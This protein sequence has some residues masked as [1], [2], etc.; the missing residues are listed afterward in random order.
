M[1]TIPATSLPGLIGS[2]ALAF[3]TAGPA[4][5][6]VQQPITPN[7]FGPTT[8]GTPVSAQLT[9]VG[10][11]GICFNWS[12]AGNVP[13]G[14]SLANTVATTSATYQGTPT[15]PSANP[16]LFEVF[17]VAT[18]CPGA[19]QPNPVTLIQPMSHVVNAAA[20]GISPLTAP[21][22]AVGVAYSQT[23]TQTGGL[24]PGSVGLSGG[25]LPPGL[26]LTRLGNTAVLAGT[27]ST[28]GIYGFNLVAA[29]VQNNTIIRSYTVVISSATP[30][31]FVTGPALPAAAVG[32]AYSVTLQT[33]GGVPPV[34]G[35][36]DPDP[37]MPPGLTIDMA[38]LTIS[39]TPAAA[40]DYSF[41][42][43]AQDALSNRTSRTFTLT[44]LPA[45]RIITTSLPNGTVSQPYYAQIQTEGSPGPVTFSY[46]G[47][48]PPGL[49]L[50]A[51]NGVVSGAPSSAGRFSF[52]VTAASGNRSTAPAGY[53]VTIGLPALDFT[54]DVLPS[55]AVGKAYQAQFTPVGGNGQYRFSP[56][57]GTNLPPG[58][59]LSSS[60]VVSGT[61]ASEGI[62]RFVVGLTS[63]DESVEKLVRITIEPPALAIGPDSLPEG[64]RG[65]AYQ[66]SLSATGGTSPY[67]F[68]IASGQLPA[69]IALSPAGAI[70][71][72]PTAAG[73]SRFTVEVTDAAKR[74]GSREYTIAVREE[75]RIT[76]ES[77]PAGAQ[78]EA[79]AGLV[80]AAGGLGPYTFSIAS[81]A[82]PTGVALA[83]DGRLSG[84]PA[85]AGRF[86][87]TIEVADRGN[88]TARRAYVIDVSAALRLLPETLPAGMVGSAYSAALS[89]EGGRAPYTFTLSGGLPAGV[90]FA[91]G[92]FSGTPS[93][94]GQFNLTGRVNDARNGSATRQYVLTVAPPPAL[95]VSGSPGSGMVGSPYQA[96]FSAAGGIAPYTF[97]GENLPPG[98]SLSSGGTLA[99]TPAQPGK[100]SFRITAAGAFNTQGSASFEITIGLPAAPPPAITIANPSVGA[101][102][103]TTI[104]LTL[105]SPYPAAITGF[106]ELTFEPVRGGDDPAI[107]FS[108]GSRRISY[109]IPAG[110]TSAVFSP[111]PA[112]VQT[113]TVAGTI[114]LLTTMLA[115]GV[116]ITPSPRPSSQIRIPPGPPVIT[117]VEVSRTATGSDLIVFG[118]ATTRE[119][120]QGVLRLAARS[121]VTLSQTDFT[122]PLSSVFSTWYS[123]AQSAP[124]GSQFR[125]VIPLTGVNT[126]SVE[127]LTIQLTNPVGS[128]DNV[129]F[130]F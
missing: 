26:T 110:A 75:L 58:L 45:F 130:T 38:T 1:R 13:P 92:S 10:Y 107:Q 103:Q 86:T 49:S 68:R 93:Q 124:F 25:T 27:P 48:L 33:T 6:Q 70:A 98:L 94:S 119:I 12:I 54:P 18:A 89:A 88:R 106:V 123:S 56:G 55:G 96:Q 128:S 41:T 63:G 90:T 50:N 105:A 77:L 28:A 85:Q 80:E 104:T 40:G 91:N 62:F 67:T 17:A 84:T 44:V 76:T 42:V 11:Q 82:L 24:G 95:T 16:Y 101:N 51:S 61:P 39:G 4:G 111:S 2:I 87:P 81:G 100:F 7:T 115:G 20:L 122:I 29:D 30:L 19:Q 64:T 8:A 59:S 83:S 15:T 22:G 66:A 53:T 31:S 37:R 112:A 109:T 9:A 117:R 126:E 43:I 5:A 14:M 74:T 97:S 32:V 78:G 47:S 118:Y 102:Q 65:A 69:G 121:G 34:S 35:L 52:A 129:R 116:D 99:G 108:N 60:G 71:G 114:T 57:P 120:T 23:F 73:S 79:Y 113:G 3:V 46:T 127:S 36:R 72:S 125:L 21:N